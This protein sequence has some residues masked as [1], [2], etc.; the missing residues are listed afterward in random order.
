MT[1]AALMAA[2]T[3]WAQSEQRVEVLEY[4]GREQK[5]PLEHVEVAVTGAATVATDSHG[6]VT[7]RFRQLKAGD[8][9]QVRRVELAGY[10][11]FNVE[12]LEQWAVSPSATFTIVMCRSDRFRQMCD[13]YSSAASES[14]ARQLK[15]DKERLANERKAGK[16]K[17]E[18]YERQLQAVQDAY[19][20]QLEQL[21]VYVERFARIDLSELSEDEAAIIALVQQGQ[22]D[23]AIARYEQLN[24]LDA[25][26]QQSDDLRQIGAARDSLADIREAKDE[27][28]D[29]LRHILEQQA[30]LYEQLDE[31]AKVDSLRAAIRKGSPEE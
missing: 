9:V 13:Q 30:T 19:D 10:E 4:N 7:L 15:R 28:R 3:A 5:T 20:E 18:E 11:V 29:S 14:Y 26:R 16:M 22:I 12:A 21:D 24:L 25:Y 31:Q 8:P 6:Q 2:T 17:Q 27:T 23:E 1:A